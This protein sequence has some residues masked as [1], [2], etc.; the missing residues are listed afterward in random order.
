VGRPRKP[1]RRGWGAVRE[2]PSGRYQASVLGPDLHRYTA[3]RT[4]ETR[5]DAEGWLHAERRYMDAAE[6]DWVPPGERANRPG[7][8]AT[9]ADYAEGALGRRMTRAGEP[10]RP[11]TLDLYRT[12]FDR[13]V[14]DDLGAMPLRSVGPADVVRWYSTLDAT[15]PTQ[16]AHAYALVHGLFAQAIREKQIPEPNPCQIDGAH[17]AQH[18]RDLDPATPAEITAI[19][20]AMPERLRLLVLLAAWCGLRYGELA[21]LRRR[22]VREAAGLIVVERAVYRVKGTDVVGPPKTAA[23][24]RRVSVPP[25]IMPALVDHLERFTG[26]EPDALLFGRAGNRHPV[27]REVSRTFAAARSVAGRPDLRLHDLRH[28]SA[29]MAARTGATVKELMERLGHGTPAM[30][31]HYQHVAAGRDQEIAAA[32]SRMAEGAPGAD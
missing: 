10:L 5:M 6:A 27:A 25:H 19:A 17:K 11:G 22:D 20:D 3:P 21:E 18:S 8:G 32:M 16:R 2:L 24:R 29:V 23:G 31:L 26:P 30:A 4:F 1:T 28:T 15:K 9:L 12:V 14:R 13:L 7:V